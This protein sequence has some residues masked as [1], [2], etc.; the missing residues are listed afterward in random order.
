MTSLRGIHWEM[1][2]IQ[3]LELR[4]ALIMADQIVRFIDELRCVLLLD[5]HTGRFLAKFG[6]SNGRG[7]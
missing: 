5:Y 4:E 6:E 7:T 1:L 3:D 2:L